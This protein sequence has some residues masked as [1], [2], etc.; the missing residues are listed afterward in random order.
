VNRGCPRTTLAQTDEFLPNYSYF[1]W[2]FGKP[3]EVVIEVVSN[4]ED[5]EK[6]QKYARMRV[7]YYVIYDP[8]R[9]V[10]PDVLTVYV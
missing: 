2:E 3:L 5:G 9:Q 10:M 6:H 7:I 1:L 8:L 4:T